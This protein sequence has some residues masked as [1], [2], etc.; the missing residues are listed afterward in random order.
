[1]SDS[2]DVGLGDPNNVLNMSW[3][4]TSTVR[5]VASGGYR[6]GDE[7]EGALVNVKQCALS[8]F[9]NHMLSEFEGV[10]DHQTRVANAHGVVLV[11][12]SNVAGQSIR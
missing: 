3:M 5:G 11:N 6:R 7:G 4:N 1:M 8:P 10:V 9:K 2:R 12:P